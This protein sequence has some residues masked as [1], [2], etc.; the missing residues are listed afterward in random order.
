MQEPN[1]A[2]QIF[3]GPKLYKKWQ[4][5]TEKNENDTACTVFC[6]TKDE[7][8]LFSD[9]TII[10]FVVLPEII[11]FVPPNIIMGKSELF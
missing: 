11:N 1:K 3:F 2:T 6:N 9:D 10:P 7:A 8:D 4:K 5:K